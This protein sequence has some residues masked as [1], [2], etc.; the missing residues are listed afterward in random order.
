M[1]WSFVLGKNERD[2]GMKECTD[3]DWVELPAKAIDFDPIPRSGL[4][5]FN[6]LTNLRT[7]LQ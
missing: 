1:A 4:R 2:E 6:D 7:T 3:S 5:K